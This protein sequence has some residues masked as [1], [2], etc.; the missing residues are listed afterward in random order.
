MTGNENFSDFMIGVVEGFYSKP[1]S[2]DQRQ[3]LYCKMKNFGLNTYVYAPKDDAKHRALW[4]ELYSPSEIDSLKQLM[5]KCKENNVIFVYGISPGLDM[6]YSQA[7]ELD[8]LKAKLDQLKQAG[9][10][11][12]CLLWDDIDTTLPPED[13]DAFETLAEA[14]VA[15]TNKIYAHLG[16]PPFLLCPTEYCTSRADPNVKNSNYLKTLGNGLDKEIK[17]F[18]TGSKVVSETISVEEMVELG[19]VLRRKP[20]IWD[21]LHANDYDQQRLFL[22]PFKGRSPKLIH[23]ISGVLTNPN[24]E[25]SFNVPVLFTLGSWYRSFQNNCGEWD[26]M[27]A[28]RESIPHFIEEINRVTTVS[29]S[30]TKLQKNISKEDELKESEIELL[31]HLYWLPHSHGP[32]AKLMLDE[33]D[34]LKEN[35]GLMQ[36]LT[37]EDIDIEVS[38]GNNDVDSGDSVASSL[39]D[40]SQST[41][42]LEWVKRFSVFNDY[43]KKI[44]RMLDK[45]TYCRNR[46]L[47][48]DI[49][50]YL[51]NLQVILR[52]CNRYLKWISFEKCTKPING[53]P[54]LAGLMGGFAGDLQRLYPI[55]HPSM[56]PL[57]NVISSADFLVVRPFLAKEKSQVGNYLHH[58]SDS[59]D[60]MV[61]SMSMI[62]NSMTNIFATEI[63]KQNDSKG[64]LIEDAQRNS[65]KAFIICS[66]QTGSLLTSVNKVR[67]QNEDCTVKDEK[68]DM[69]SKYDC[70]ATFSCTRSL[71]FSKPLRS[72]FEAFFEAY[73]Q[74]KDFALI[75]DKHDDLVLSFLASSGLQMHKTFDANTY[76]VMKRKN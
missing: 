21:N 70:L 43:C 48:F 66:Q 27:H 9:C 11:G 35:A 57:R 31:F 62:A 39:E 6:S 75:A 65:V 19:Q 38:G 17:V 23:E 22:G 14:H 40:M 13:G 44:C 60:H 15:V 47:F 7:R 3:D 1:W 29:Q 51:N 18:W 20:L 32:K 30:S 42:V 36:S 72:M 24:C 61:V 74:H 59:V 73:V 76:V 37:L 50:P 28:S 12:Y 67:K 2:M 41:F 8:H 5:D 26:P 55:Q 71:F 45:W 25:Y 56:F 53:G 34:F 10:E 68:I 46:E 64:F 33:F 49:N 4:R 69:L 63:S 16:R 54:T 58:M 52:A